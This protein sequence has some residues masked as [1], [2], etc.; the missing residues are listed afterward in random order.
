MMLNPTKVA[1]FLQ[2]AKRL[3]V[4]LRRAAEKRGGRPE[5]QNALSLLLQI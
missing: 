2:N 4:I 1:F 3:P 5:K